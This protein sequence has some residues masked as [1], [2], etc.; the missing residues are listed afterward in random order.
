MGEILFKFPRHPQLGA[1]IKVTITIL[2]E[3]IFLWFLVCLLYEIA[4]PVYS[5]C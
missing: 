4:A 1:K 5:S 2:Y 3:I